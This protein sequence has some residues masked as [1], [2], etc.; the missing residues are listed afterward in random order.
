MLLLFNAYANRFEKYI[1]RSI[2]LPQSSR[3]E[4]SSGM[5]LKGSE[6]REALR[7]TWYALE[8]MERPF[9]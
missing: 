6:Q 7:Q 3:Y 1:F 4:C 5:I 8:G 9:I 2:V